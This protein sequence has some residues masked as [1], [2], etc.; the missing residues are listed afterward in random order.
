M[1]SPY[2]PPPAPPPPKGRALH[3]WLGIATGALVPLLTFVPVWVFG[4]D[5]VPAAIGVIGWAGTMLAGFLLL[6]FR[7]TRRF[8]AGMIIGFWGLIIVGA[9]TCTVVVLSLGMS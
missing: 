1:T 6:V 8:G 2:V 5:S 4:L 7:Q 3:L 9:G